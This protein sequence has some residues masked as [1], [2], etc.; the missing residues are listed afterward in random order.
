MISCG[1]IFS[2]IILVINSFPYRFIDILYGSYACKGASCIVN[3]HLQA[4]VMTH[5][6]LRFQKRLLLFSIYWL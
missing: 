3:S 5:H 6:F 2:F 1:E 4:S